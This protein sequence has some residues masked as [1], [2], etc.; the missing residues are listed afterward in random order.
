MR[1]APR[2]RKP[3]TVPQE[4]VAAALVRVAEDYAQFVTD[5]PREDGPPDPK[6]FAARQAA[7][8]AALAH[9]AELTDLAAGGGAPTEEQE[10]DAVLQRA[11][12][13]L[14]EDLTEEEGK[15]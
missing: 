13:E 9:I 10:T 1:K 3:L 7:A 4:T 8:R 12:A 15:A 6:L 14:R 5:A 2:G 11:R